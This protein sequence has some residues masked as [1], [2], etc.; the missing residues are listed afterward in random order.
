MSFAPITGSA[1]FQDQSLRQQAGGNSLAQILRVVL[2]AL[3]AA[4]GI[5][6]AML[7]RAG[8]AAP[9]GQHHAQP[10]LGRTALSSW[11]PAA[12]N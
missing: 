10:W 2:L 5:G 1:I 4:L 8:H 12:A 6:L 9:A 11:A 3:L 7:P